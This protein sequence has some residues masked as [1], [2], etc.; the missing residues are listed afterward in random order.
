MKTIL[1]ICC[2]AIVNA[3]TKINAA[4]PVPSLAY[5]PVETILVAGTLHRALL[6]N[7]TTGDN[8]GELPGQT[9]RV[10][11]LAF[12]APGD[13]LAI[14]GGEPG[15]SGVIRIYSFQG[16]SAKLLHD[17]PAA[18][19]D[20]IYALTFSPD[21]KTLASAGYDR[22][23]KLWNVEKPTEPRLLE[24]HSDTIYALSFHPDGKLLA[25]A[26]ADR[27][28]K[29]WDVALGKRLYTLGDSTDWVYTATWSP[30]GKHLAAAGVD[31]S[32]R[33][34]QADAEGGKLAF[35]VFAH[36]QPVTRIAYSNDGKSLYSISEGKNLK[37]WD[38][39]TVKE[40]LVFPPESETML[41]MAVSPDQKQVAV[42]LFDGTLKLKNAVDGKVLFQP[43]P[44]K[45][46]LPA[47]NKLSPEAGQ[48]GTTTRVTIVGSNLADVTSV[49]VD[50]NQ[51]AA[52]VLERKADSVTLELTVPAASPAGFANLSI[53][54]AAGTSAL[55]PFAIDRYR[56][57]TETG[58]KDSP[59]IGL[60]IELPATLVGSINKA[61][62]A[63]YFRFTATK[64]QELAVQVL[65]GS[66]KLEPVLELTDADGRVL[67]ESGKG[68]LGYRFEAAGTYA[69]GIR[70]KDFR[71]GAD[72]TYRVS[73]GPF[74]LVLGIS[75]LSVE[76]GK[77]SPVQLLGVNLG[78]KSI[79]SVTVPPDAAIDKKL[80]VL[81]PELAEKPLGT[82]Q[83][84]VNEFPQVGVTNDK[85][86][87]AVPGSATGIVDQPNAV[88]AVD[89]PAKK[90]QRLIVE[91][92]ARRHGSPLDSTIDIVD[93]RNKPVLRATLRGT[94]RTYST[95]RDNDS[96]APG[97]RLEAWNELN[98]DDYLYM[99]GELMRIKALPKGP[100]DDCQFYQAGGMRQGYLDTTP[101][102]HA[103]GSPM[104]K[105]EFH[106]PGTKFPPNGLP[107]FDLPFRND[108]GGLGYGKDSRIFFDPPA[109][110][111]YR[112]ML[113]D[114]R[115]QGGSAHTYRLTVRPP[116]PSFLVEFS[117]ISPM[118][119]KGGSVPISATATRLD[120]FDG[121]IELEMTDLPKGFVAPNSSIEAGQLTTVFPL[122][123]ETDSVEPKQSSFSFVASGTAKRSLPLEELKNPMKKAVMEP[124]T[125]F[126]GVLS[127]YQSGGTLKLR[128]PGDIVTTTDL[129]ELTIRPG[130]Q[131]KLKV[132]V[133]RRN[134]FA[135][136]IP[137]DVRGLP[138]GVRVMDIGLNGILLTPRDTEREIVLYAEPWVQPMTRP[139][140]VLA[141]R[142]GAKTEHG[143][144][145]VMLKVVK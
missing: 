96:A 87:I 143:A 19:K 68:L 15:K 47:I 21:G 8:V 29:V 49:N 118:V 17:L 11:A 80:N 77:T 85:A 122:F 128:E 67:E 82:V 141:T 119:W 115:G 74:P 109:D 12:N 133:E 106:P 62:D 120:G 28:V 110:S 2:I 132:K 51:V 40:R 14:A 45:P 44:A 125:L 57:L 72:F 24:D 142:E 139:L 71:G 134:G 54:T 94:A 30:D 103:L 69:L 36:T 91:V 126:V 16:Q 93:M 10:T 64:G 127:L 117:P 102:H 20:I 37:V 35:S 111:T 66:S 114:S 131:A 53:T 84:L 81:L 76:R 63:D 58:P 137:L 26:A 73:A 138:H 65:T 60:K 144:R 140:I 32:I 92:D 13:R 39:A 104:Y 88:H 18:H 59:R 46:K 31:K 61:G 50:M 105:V 55:L 52:K 1:I 34:W 116:K 56:V 33:I 70:D 42:G 27:A 3:D 97:I 75:P 99:N 22:V 101:I 25:S 98:I 113:R 41:S 100:D 23:I 78:A 123:A 95:F 38:A 112:V 89:F 136:R 43:L 7:S 129:Q 135:G 107:T 86:V 108:D 124:L 4:P 83:V 5:H 121:A 6:V 9:G 90:G 145:P 48:R 130:E 79:V